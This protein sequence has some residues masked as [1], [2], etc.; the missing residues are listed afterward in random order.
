MN[1][2]CALAMSVSHMTVPPLLKINKMVS[3]LRAHELQRSTMPRTSHNNEI[4]KGTLG[5]FPIDGA[6]C[7]GKKVK[8]I[9]LV[10][11]NRVTIRL[12]N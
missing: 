2:G 8:Q 12:H 7:G 3:A 6:N 4:Y 1:G 5:D 10:G 11:F 9:N